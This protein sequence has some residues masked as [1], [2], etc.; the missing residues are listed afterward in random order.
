MNIGGRDFATLLRG[1]GQRGNWI[2]LVNML[3]SYERPLGAFRRYLLASGTYPHVFTLRSPAGAV[4][5]TAYSHDDLLTIN[6]IFCRRDYPIR[7]TDRV[8][9]D[10]G[11]NIGISALYFLTHAPDC[12]VHC[13]EPL[14]SNC[15]RLRKTLQGYERRYHLAPCAISVEEGC[16][17]FAYEP[18]GRYGGIGEVGGIGIRSSG[19]MAVSALRARDVIAGILKSRA[20]IDVLKIDI[21]AMER[22]VL[23]SL[24]KSQLERIDRIYVELR[25]DS[26]PLLET[27]A[28]QQYGLVAQFRNKNWRKTG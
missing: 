17:D 20:R 27:H 18:T 3:G 15:D 24:P 13:H 11:S 28:F 2:A 23:L 25:F 6:E 9:V 5:V 10:F 14:P 1:A 16:V 12:F 4:R 21:E 8:V 7:P 19:T 22:D 26:N